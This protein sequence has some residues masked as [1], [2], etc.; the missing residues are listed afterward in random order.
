MGLLWLVVGCQGDATGPA[1]GRIGP[2][3]GSVSL[4]D[5]AVVLTVPAGALLE[6]VWF[7]AIP[8]VAV[9]AAPPAVSGTTYELGPPGTL[10]GNP[11]TITVR[12]DPAKLPQGTGATDLGVFL[13]QG[14]A[15]SLA[16]TPAVNPA[17]GTVSGQV[18][19]LGRVGVLGIPVAAVEVSPSSVTLVPGGSTLLAATLK[20]ESGGSLTGRSV[21]WSTSDSAVATVG[22][23]GRVTG[24]GEGSAVVTALSDGQSGTAT[25]SV[26]IPVASVEVNPGAAELKVGGKVQLTA[27][28]LDSQGNPLQGRTVTWS[29]NDVRVAQVDGRGLVTALARGSTAIT[30]RAGGQVGTAAVTVHGDLSVTTASLARGVVGAPYSQA[31]A[32]AGGDGDYLWSVTGGSLPSGLSLGTETGLISGT[33]SEA[34]S[35][36]FTVKVE[37]A[38]QASTRSLAIAVDPVPVASVTL[39]PSDVE[40]TLGDTLRLVATA[41]DSAGSVLTGRPVVWASSDVNAVTVSS[42]GLLTA[43]SAGT[44]TVTATVAGFPGW[45]A[46]RVNDVL[47][48]T[49][50]LLR[51]GVVGAS[52]RD[53][54]AAV[55][56]NGSY[57]WTLAGGA[58]PGGLSLAEATGIISGTPMAAGISMFAVE[59]TS[60]DGQVAS[61]TMTMTVYDGLA[62]STG[63]LPDGVVG[64]GYSQTLA[65]SGGNPPY[66]WTLATGSLPLGLALN[67]I[68]GAI[69]GT[70]TTEGTSEFSVD[71]RSHDGQRATR[72]F[73][74][75]V[76]PVPVASVEL[77]PTSAGLV[78]GET[79]LLTAV[80]RDAS[81]SDLTGRPVSWASSDEGVAIVSSGGLVTAA[82]VGFA[83]VT[84]SVEGKMATATVTVY[85]LLRV[86]TSS[87]AGGNVGASYDQALAATG[88]NGAY[89]WWVSAG[90]LPDGLVL[91]PDT[92]LVSGTPTT[93]GSW[94]FTVQVESGDGQ[95]ATADLSITV[96]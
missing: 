96:G 41:R 42:T 55:G 90:A 62:V 85:S 74:L 86:L 81:G 75:T 8:T 61:A 50:T 69:S 13:V 67:T 44:S 83:L 12:Y 37:S 71:V 56:G 78:S 24:V 77:S 11:I 88:G 92:G 29:S 15:W 30:A 59:V 39:S 63:T 19:R 76:D 79:V 47:A 54:L 93:P 16:G 68:S 84:A 17:A 72:V 49:D 6:E 82:G 26:T 22:S 70:P 64:S 14:D 46:V 94:A 57:H 18:T 35:R 2:A 34:G 20:A 95:T 80:V 21:T 65:A 45:A 66:T 4:E 58:L 40:L 87:L 60:S 10:F 7:T 31:L 3:G 9:P 51:T 91:D 1:E 38:G 33:P 73:S 52:Y 23:D 28:P 89:T 43:L 53:T 48:V 25:V 5:G 36:T 27:T 32:A